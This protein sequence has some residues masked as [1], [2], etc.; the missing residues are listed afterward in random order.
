MVLLPIVTGSENVNFVAPFAPVLQTSPIGANKLP[1]PKT[2]RPFKLG[3]EYT[4]SILPKPNSCVK[5][6]AGLAA[7]I[8]T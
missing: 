3:L 5:V 4:I 8:F 1:A 7:G 2:G 6:C